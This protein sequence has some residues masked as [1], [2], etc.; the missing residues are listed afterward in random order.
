MVDST[1]VEL[2][3]KLTTVHTNWE[4]NL[5]NQR[6]KGVEVSGRAME[7]R[8][9]YEPNSEIWSIMVTDT[10]TGLTTSG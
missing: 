1:K 6:V 7:L 4:N 8:L 2:L 10:K 9:F 3:A 5:T